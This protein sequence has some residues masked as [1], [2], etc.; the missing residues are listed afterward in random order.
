MALVSMGTGWGSASGQDW[1]GGLG[2]RRGELGEQEAQ[3]AGKSG[4]Y[5]QEQRAGTGGLHRLRVDGASG[6]L[7]DDQEPTPVL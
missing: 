4:M 6:G 7:G 2:R 1:G 5:G 3:P